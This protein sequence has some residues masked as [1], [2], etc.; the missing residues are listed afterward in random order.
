MLYEE[1]MTTPARVKHISVSA[2]L[3]VHLVA[4]S[5]AV[6]K[7]STARPLGW[8][9]L[10]DLELGVALHSGETILRGSVCLQTRT[11]TRRV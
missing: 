1:A 11:H 7:A 3:L 8:A 6:E 4:M 5:V 10:I 2:Y 9:L